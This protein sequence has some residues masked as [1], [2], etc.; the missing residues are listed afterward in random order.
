MRKTIMRCVAMMI[1]IPKLFI[2]SKAADIP[3][4]PTN[5]QILHQ[6]EE[7]ARL[8]QQRKLESA[9]EHLKVAMEIDPPDYDAQFKYATVLVELGKYNEAIAILQTIAAAKPTDEDVW[10]TLGNCYASIAAYAKASEAY[11]KACGLTNSEAAEYCQD[12]ESKLPSDW[13]R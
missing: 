12:F 2:S 6:V 9:A 7:G 11:G 1:I 10:A 5:A 3:Q 13:S 4:N 8:L